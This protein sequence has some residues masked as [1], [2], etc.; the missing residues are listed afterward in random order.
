MT[1]PSRSY[2]RFLCG[3]QAHPCKHSG[4]TVSGPEVEFDAATR[5]ELHERMDAI[6]RAQL[7]ALAEARYYVVRR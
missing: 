2:E 4:R 7:V 5:K 1:G 6:D 3:C